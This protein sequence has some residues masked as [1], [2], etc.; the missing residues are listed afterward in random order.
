MKIVP[1]EVSSFSHSNNIQTSK[2][3]IAKIFDGDTFKIKTASS[4]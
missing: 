3:L 4:I 2:G 1:C